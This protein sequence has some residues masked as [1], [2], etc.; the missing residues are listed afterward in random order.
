M[1]V[2][3]FVQMHPCGASD[4]IGEI[5]EIINLFTYLYL[6]S[7]T[8]RLGCEILENKF[9]GMNGRFKPIWQNIIR[10]Y[11]IDFRQQIL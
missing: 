7:P 5:Y 11:S 3:N 1:G 10:N 9:C 4:H 2:L 8:Q 6:S